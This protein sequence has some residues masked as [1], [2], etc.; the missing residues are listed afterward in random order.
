MDCVAPPSS[1]TAATDLFRDRPVEVMQE[2][3]TASQPR[4]RPLI[5]RRRLRH[6]RIATRAR[7]VLADWSVTEQALERIPPRPKRR[8]RR[9]ARRNE[10]LQLPKI[11]AP[12]AEVG[13]IAGTDKQMT[14]LAPREDGDLP[15]ET[16]R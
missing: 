3:E 1:S 14:V 16:C 11:R 6:R 9:E 10:V 13:E 4:G 2:T 7:A 5:A 15:D 8:P 12:A